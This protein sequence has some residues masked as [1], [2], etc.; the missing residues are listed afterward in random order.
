MKKA[1]VIIVAVAVLGWLGFKAQHK[2]DSSTG[3][4]NQPANSA[5]QISSQTADAQSS[6]SGGAAPSGNYKDGTYNGST[7]GTPYGNVQVAAVISGGKIVDIKFLQMPDSEGESIMHTNQSEPLL[8]QSALDN[9]NAHIDFVT[10]ATDTSFGFEQ[11][12]QAALN[13]AS[14]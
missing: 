6:A 7:S 9:Q 12:L 1:I 3:V 14:A 4:A 13:Q 8:K 2:T 5:A 10:G 11:S